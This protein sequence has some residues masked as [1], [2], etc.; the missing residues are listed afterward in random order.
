[1]NNGYPYIK[2]VDADTIRLTNSFSSRDPIYNGPYYGAGV[3]GQLNIT[4]QG[5]LYTWGTL[6]SMCS[7]QTCTY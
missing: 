3:G 4:S 1:M 7:N 2:Y 6:F 5:N